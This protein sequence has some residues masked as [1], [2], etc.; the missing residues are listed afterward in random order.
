M[1][2]QFAPV[3]L[4]QCAYLCAVALLCGLNLHLRVR[5]ITKNSIVSNIREL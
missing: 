5:E 3:I 2:V 1:P 4:V